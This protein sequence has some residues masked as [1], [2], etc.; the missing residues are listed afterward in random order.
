MNTPDL[1]SSNIRDAFAN[2]LSCMDPNLFPVANTYCRSLRLR[3]L[4]AMEPSNNPA[5]Q[6]KHGDQIPREVKYSKRNQDK[7]MCSWITCQR[8]LKRR[9]S[10]DKSVPRAIRHYIVIQWQW[11]E[12]TRSSNIG[13][14]PYPKTENEFLLSKR[15]PAS[16]VPLVVHQAWQR[17]P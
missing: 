9:E 13:V 5:K 10:S 4:A 15:S 11:T 16:T 12:S 1:E 8:L 3:C 14:P 6:R 7:T 17:L 2:L